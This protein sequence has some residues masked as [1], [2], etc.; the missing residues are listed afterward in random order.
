[1]H[2]DPHPPPH[3]HTHWVGSWIHQHDKNRCIPRPQGIAYQLTTHSPFYNNWSTPCLRKIFNW[4]PTSSPIHIDHQLITT[5]APVRPS[6]CNW[7]PLCKSPPAPPIY[8]LITGP[9]SYSST[10]DWYTHMKQWMN[11]LWQAAVDLCWKIV[12]QIIKS[13]KHFNWPPSSPPFPNRSPPTTPFLDCCVHMNNRHQTFPHPTPP[14]PHTHSPWNLK[15][16]FLHKVFSSN[17][18]FSPRHSHIDQITCN[19]Q[20]T[21]IRFININTIS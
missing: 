6:F 10:D 16:V 20:Y 1:M 13:L 2:T 14:R 8:Q 12:D 17:P 4:S 9:I 15:Y 3:T 5:C 21:H 18:T 7:S 11:G 19:T